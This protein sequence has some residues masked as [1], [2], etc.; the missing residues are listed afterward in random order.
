[1]KK[2]RIIIYGVL[3]VLLIIVGYVVFQYIEFNNVAKAVGGMPWQDG[4]KISMVRPVC[5]L[6]TPMPYPTTCAISCPLVTSAY[7]TACMAY[8]EIDTVGQ[9]GTT[10]MAVPK[11]FVF[12]GG[13][14]F[15]TTGMDFVAGGSTNALPWV[16]G[17][18][19]LAVNNIEK[20]KNW[21]DKY[22]IAGFKD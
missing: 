12:S 9:K 2:S 19:G 10:F 4:G 7:G 5:I 11:G 18:P 17:I 13:G 20:I 22:I 21:F 14:S 6:D 8:M 1:M 16:I 3:T 15:P